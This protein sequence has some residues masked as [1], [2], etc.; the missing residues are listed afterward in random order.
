MDRLIEN[1]PDKDWRVVKQLANQIAGRRPGRKHYNFN[2]APEHVRRGRHSAFKDI[3]SADRPEV[4]RWIK[5]DKHHH[6]EGGSLANGLRHVFR[7]MHHTYKRDLAKGG[8]GNFIDRIG[9]TLYNAGASIGTQMDVTADKFLNDIGITKDRK[10]SAVATAEDAMHAR[11]HQDAYMH[12][13]ERKGSDGWDYMR[14][15][16]TDERAVYERDGKAMVLFRGTRP[17]A[18]LNNNDLVNDLHIAAGNSGS[19]AGLAD[20]K[21][22]V[23]QLLD[24]Y[25]DHNVNVGGYSLGGG[26]GIEVMRDQD[27][28]KR[29][30]EDNHFLAPGI[31]V[32]HDDLSGVASMTKASFTYAHNDMVANAL[33]GHARDNHRILTHYGD[34]ISGH[35][36]LDDLASSHPEGSAP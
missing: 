9:N 25:G 6:V 11:L 35:M 4:M 31:T 30:G 7:V 18:A 3:A 34:G 24:Q 26:R 20:D 17:D 16:S 28:Y 29:L 33:A 12:P 5:G 36:F 15:H 21:A 23:N 14:D 13:D 32:A 2:V 19:M 27:I 8:S 10:Y 22:K 1:L